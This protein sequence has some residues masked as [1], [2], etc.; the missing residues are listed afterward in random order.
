MTILS[1]FRETGLY[2]YK[3]SKVL[4]KLQAREEE[5]G[6]E[7]NLWEDIDDFEDPDESPAQQTTPPTRTI[8]NELVSTP[9]MSRT[10]K[11]TFDSVL[12]TPLLPS[13]RHAIE[14]LRKTCVMKTTS[15]ILLSHELACMKAAEVA[16]AA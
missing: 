3:P 5:M 10:I 15:E 13:A 12:E 8:T 16:R 14:K 2:L 7:E 4:D 11:R 6:Q 1:A 9:Q